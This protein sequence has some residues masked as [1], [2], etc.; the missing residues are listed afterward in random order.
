MKRYLL[1]ANAGGETCGGWRDFIGSFEAVEPAFEAAYHCLR[2]DCS[3]AH[4][5][6]VEAGKVVP[7]PPRYAVRDDR[8]GSVVAGFAAITA[9]NA[10]FRM[11]IPERSLDELSVG[12]VMPARSRSE[13]Y[14]IERVC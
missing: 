14:R 7:I 2:N 8:D 11:I 9:D 3:W 10:V 5:V 6:D 12:Q 13:R 4:V 1:F